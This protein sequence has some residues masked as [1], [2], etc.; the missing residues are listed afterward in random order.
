MKPDLL[1]NERAFI[2]CLLRNPHEYWDAK[3]LIRIEMLTDDAHR[4]IYE[5]VG[6]L[7]ERGRQVSS[8]TLQAALPEEY[9]DGKPYV[10]LIAVLKENAAEAGSALDYADV[11]REEFK[12]R[13]VLNL[14][15][16]AGKAAKDPSKAT[17]DILAEIETELL[18]TVRDSEFSN[19]KWLHDAAQESLSSTAENFRV[20]EEI[21]IGLRTGIQELDSLV[22][23]VMGGD[24]VTLAAPSGHGKGQPL[25]A[26]VLTPQGYRKMG[27]LRVGHRVCAPD[28]S[29][30]HVIGIY[31]LG[32]RQI[33][34]VN[35]KDGTS[36]EVTS[37]HLWLTWPRVGARFINGV[38]V[39]GEAGAKIYT[40]ERMIEM[41]A[42]NPR[43]RF[44]IP[45]TKP[46]AI[47]SSWPLKV[48]P[49]V[50][51]ALLGDG[52]FTNTTIMLTTEDAEI[53]HRVSNLLGA[54][55]HGP[56]TSKGKRAPSYGIPIETGVRD[57]LERTGLLGHRSEE[58]FIPGIYLHR[59]AA[60]RWELLR[61]MMDTDGWV[62]VDGDPRFCSKSK[63]LSDDLAWLA[64]SLG[65]DVNVREKPSWY[66]KNGKRVDCGIAYEVRVKFLDGADA[67]HLE[68]KKAKCNKPGSVIRTIVSIEPCRMAQAQCIKVSHPSSLYITNDFIVTH[69]TTLA[70]QII[71][72]AARPGVGKPAFFVSM[73]M[74]ATQIARRAMAA[75]AEVSVRKQRAGDIEMF[76]YERL[77]SA[78]A[79]AAEVQILI[80][81]TG[82]QTTSRICKK[83]RAMHR[84]YGLGCAAI[85]HVLLI[86]PD[87]PRWQKIETIEYAAMAFKELAKEL[88]IPIFLLAQLTRGS[89]T[90]AS[91][92]RFTDQALY[93]GDAIK[94]ASDVMLGVTLPRKWLKQRE[95]DENDAR[96]H[97]EWVRKMEHWKDR[98]EIGALKMR[99][100]DDGNWLQMPFCGSTYTFGT[101]AA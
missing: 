47:Q 23:P 25:D 82:R 98:S 69:N 26:L 31:P 94:Q 6:D 65:A 10:A 76:E 44:Y 60:D 40:T 75:W 42:A 28:G 51:G 17:D 67:F 59:P 49:Y 20:R 77:R 64:R 80:D 55:L 71:H 66:R 16:K 78:A 68:R 83:V 89:Q 95:P 12:R 39:T 100:D 90:S 32:E 33:Y 38:K 2:G 45:V 46:V 9:D 21:Q 79:R 54:T 50:M 7:M 36:T 91:S 99:D 86:K 8:S 15:Q 85:D 87:N 48:P 18:S 96:A 24:L 14:V 57:E 88:D 97:D 101:R 72:H 53:A 4:G 58:K 5:A 35:F 62:N 63:R 3:D 52:G 74:Q 73:E 43:M 56:Q 34:K 30:C 27:D 11:I 29:I 84:R 92:W 13:R 22:G 81:E 61:G 1:A 37:D 70:M 19:I 41:F 93:G